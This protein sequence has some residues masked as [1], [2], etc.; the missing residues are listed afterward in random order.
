MLKHV[1]LFHSAVT[2]TE[3]TL[4]AEVVRPAAPGDWKLNGTLHGPTNQRA[5]SLPTTWSFQD[6]GPGATLLTK[7]RI[8]DPCPWSLDLPAIYHVDLELT[9]DGVLVDQWQGVTGLRDFG[10]AGHSFLRNGER[11]VLRGKVLANPADFDANPWH[12]ARLVCVCE[13]P[14]QEMLQQ[15][16]EVGA[17]LMVRVTAESVETELQRIAHWP[18]VMGVILPTVPDTPW[19]IAGRWNVAVGCVADAAGLQRW[20]NGPPPAKQAGSLGI[21]FVCVSADLAHPRLDIELAL[22]V[23]PFAPV[24]TS[25]PAENVAAPIDAADRTACDRTACDRTACDRLQ[26]ELTPGNF[27]GYLIGDLRDRKI[28][29]QTA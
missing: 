23:I 18:A 15:A 7:V 20:L 8:A 10:V 13:S 2:T 25:K 6:A 14:S 9:R 11:W 1:H 5:T 17:D 21:E 4:Y 22:P 12:A 29:L 26:A 27:A 24:A 19:Q 28:G 16:S 3:T